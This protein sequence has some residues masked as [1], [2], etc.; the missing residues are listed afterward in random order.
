MATST[1]RFAS[2]S[3][4]EAAKIRSNLHS[5][6]T[7]AIKIISKPITAKILKIF[8]LTIG[9]QTWTFSQIKH[10]STTTHY[11]CQKHRIIFQ[12]DSSIT[13]TSNTCISTFLNKLIFI[14]YNHCFI[15]NIQ[16]IHKLFTC[17]VQSLIFNR[18]VY[19]NRYLNLTSIFS[20]SEHE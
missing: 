3:C 8:N 16:L 18:N 7:V 19:L 5:K 2:T 6:E 1:S 15:V 11:Q 14:L 17:N 13:V 10:L 12:M 20:L 4:T 9:I